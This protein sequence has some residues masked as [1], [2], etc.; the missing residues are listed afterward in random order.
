VVDRATIAILA[1]APLP[2]HAKT[3]LIPAL[4]ADGAARLQAALIRHTLQ[5]A[6]ATGL[7]VTLWWDGPLPAPEPGLDLR[8]QP[9]GDLGAR[10][11]AA[12][13]TGGRVILIGT[14]AP[15]ARAEDLMDAVAAGPAVGIGAAFD[16]GY[17]CVSPPARAPERLLEALFH[18]MPWST[19]RVAAETRRRLAALGVPVRELRGLADLDTPADL[20][21]LRADPA[22]PRDL[23]PLL[24][25]VLPSP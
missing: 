11:R 21:R 2:G 4:G 8:P 25:S 1:K 23:L 9:D 19:A 10:M 7:P 22:C 16:G 12:A 24:G 14:D 20:A 3:R 5:T 18:Q 17:W 6:R 15:T 13:Q